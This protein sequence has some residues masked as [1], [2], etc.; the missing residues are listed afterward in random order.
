MGREYRINTRSGEDV[1]MSSS[2]LRSWFFTLLQGALGLALGGM[3]AYAQTATPVHWSAEVSGAHSNYRP[4]E[5][6]SV[7][8]TAEIDAGWHLYSSPQ[9]LRSPVKGV[10]ITVPG[11]QPLVMAGAIDTPKPES[12]T[13]PVVGAETRFYVDSASFKVPLKVKKRAPSGTQKLE[14]DVR[15]QMCNDRIC[16]PPR[17]DKIEVPLEIGGSATHR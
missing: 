16:L 11:G 7:E 3:K 13:D 8:I 10:E 1:A 5:K 4:G 2:R 12:K 14:L 9:P 17:T 6:L 15:Y